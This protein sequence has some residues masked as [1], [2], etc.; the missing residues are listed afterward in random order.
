MKLN[1]QQ[2][3]S[4]SE[5]K[6]AAE[7]GILMLTDIEV[8]KHQ[9]QIQRHEKR[10][11]YYDTLA[12]Q[13]QTQ[14]ESPDT[15]VAELQRFQLRAVRR[16]NLWSERSCEETEVSHAFRRGGYHFRITIF[17]ID[18]TVSVSSW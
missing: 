4:I 6:W 12:K 14:G 16:S 2:S 15:I 17:R 7:L 5:L 11:K 9:E 8:E 13:H 10:F 3:G 18:E 1:Q